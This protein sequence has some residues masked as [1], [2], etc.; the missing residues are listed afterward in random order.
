[1]RLIYPT[2]CLTYP[3]KSYSSYCCSITQRSRHSAVGIVTRIRA[4][5]AMVQISARSE[6]VQNDSGAHIASHEMGTGILSQGQS[7]RG[8]NLNIHL[9]LVLMLRICPV[10]LLPSLHAFMACTE[11][12]FRYLLLQHYIRRMKQTASERSLSANKTVF[13]VPCGWIARTAPIL[14]C[15][16]HKFGNVSTTSCFLMLS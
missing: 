5:R 3:S 11:T 1:M 8:V 7:S 12:T 2:L 13:C 9:H 16:V 15:S 14:N 4:V 10:V 6:W